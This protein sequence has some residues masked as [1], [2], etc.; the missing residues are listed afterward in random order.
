[1]SSSQEAESASP[2]PTVEPGSA[3]PDP[4]VELGAAANPTV[5]TIIAVDPGR[6]K[7]GVAVMTGPDPVRCIHRAVVE[8]TRLVVDLAALMRRFPGVKTIIIGAGTGSAPLRRALRSTFTGLTVTPVDE[9]G[10]SERARHR[11]LKENVPIGWRR[12]IPAGLR[13]PEIPY[14]DYVAIILAEEWF[15]EKM[16]NIL[17]KP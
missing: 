6:A 13:T 2:D 3:E 8:T 9:H 7:C 12:L 10:S 14:D 5:E 16:G 1:M 15:S 11:F 4:T 17:P